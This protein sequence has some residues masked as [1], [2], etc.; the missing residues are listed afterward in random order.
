MVREPDLPDLLRQLIDIGIALTNQRSLPALLSQ[1]LTEARRFTR[2][3]A[4]TLF[5]RESDHL[6]FAVVQ[7]DVLA[8]RLSPEEVDRKFRDEWLPVDGSSLAG[9]A[10]HR[11]EIINIV[12]AYALGSDRP[13]AF[14]DLF[15]N[16]FEY[17]T[18]SVLVVPMQDLT[19]RVV[20]VLELI[21][22]LDDKGQAVPFHSRWEPLIRALASQAAVAIDNVRLGELSYKDSLTGIYNRRYFSL[23]LEEEVRRRAHSGQPLSVALIDIDSFKE[24]NDTKGHGAGDYSLKELAATLVAEPARGFSVTSRYGGDEFAV[25]LADTAKPGAMGYARRIRG[26]IARRDFAYGR[27]TV[28]IGVASMPDDASTGEE[29]LLAADRALYN[30]KRAGGNGVA[31]A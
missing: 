27:L 8:G 25:L 21:N 16:R 29:L 17:R 26:A 12:D 6:R 11:N 23:R 2:A 28:S 24:I 7:N 5:M 22:A 3:E 19:A 4:G 10:A 18:H 31:T 15:D 13:Y 14:N 1:I 30:A 20:G 9:Y